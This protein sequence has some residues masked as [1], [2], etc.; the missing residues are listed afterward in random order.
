M[1]ESQMKKKLLVVGDSFMLPDPGYLEWHWSEMLPEY[2]ILMFSQS[3]NSNGLIAHQFF[4]GLALNPD[5]V[6]LGFTSPSRIEFKLDP[7]PGSG[8]N[9]NRWA[10]GAHTGINSIQKIAADYF[11]TAVC[12][13]MQ[14]F[15][16]LVIAKSLLLTLEKK[17]IPFAYTCNLLFNHLGDEIGQAQVNEI[18]GEFDNHK[19]PTNLATYP[20]WKASPGFHTDDPEWQKR[21]AKE[22]RE[23]LQRT[24]DFT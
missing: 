5:A 11:T 24:I 6:V 1:D 12:Q 17:K 13:D 23:I 9:N 7:L 15:K 4:K 3:G 19:C 14:F 2:E 16:N 18:L 20:D 10:T 21:F 22:V 8:F